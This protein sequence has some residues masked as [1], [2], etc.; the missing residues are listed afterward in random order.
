MRHLSDCDHNSLKQSSSPIDHIF[1][2]LFKSITT[3][4]VKEKV[5][6]AL[7]LKTTELHKTYTYRKSYNNF[8]CSTEHTYVYIYNKVVSVPPRKTQER[9]NGF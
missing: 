9:L 3:F 2:I 5:I 7:N 1:Q 4:C 8:V 6:C